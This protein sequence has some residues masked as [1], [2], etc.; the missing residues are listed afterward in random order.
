MKLYMEPIEVTISNGLPTALRWR[1]RHYR[2]HSVLE[3]WT[4][5]GRWWTDPPALEGDRR[6]YYRVLCDKAQL[7]IF[8]RGGSP[9][10]EEPRPSRAASPPWTL[11]RA[12]D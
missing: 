10:K 2:V 7:E 1:N 3:Q 5:R 6:T 12:L 11:S 4:Y 8:R 9:Q